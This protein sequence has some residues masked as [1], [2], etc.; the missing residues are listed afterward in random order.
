ME[1]L[2]FI[3]EPMTAS[4]FNGW[5]REDPMRS[6]SP[7]ATHR[8]GRHERTVADLRPADVTRE[9]LTRRVRWGMLT[10][11]LTLAAALVGGGFWLWQRPSAMADAAVSNI[12]TQAGALQPELTSLQ[13]I[14]QQLLEPELDLSA[15]SAQS[16]AV[17]GEARA[18]FDAS[19]AVPSSE[20]ATR[21]LAADVASTAIDASR[22]LSSATAYRSAILPILV[23]PDL[24]TDPELIGLDDAVRD[25]GAW[26]SQF[27][28]VRSA[29]PEGTLP[30]V[31]E[32]LETI[33]AGLESIQ[34]GYL[35]AL[36]EDDRTAADQ[37]V[38]DIE[39]QLR[40]VE[41]VLNVSLED[42]QTR[43][44]RLTDEAL[45]G[46]DQLLS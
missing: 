3:D 35:D 2:G 19:G 43:V 11:V 5:P 10:I 37:Q 45:A 22:I 14:N 44:H 15:V 23:P 28:E 27:D 8:R 38:R 16:A 9:L 33:S 34:A 18:L 1:A 20:A 36:R 29:L 26:Q 39:D 32:R 13:D 25:F 42:V 12:S 40:D 31:T 17:N 4:T 41:A 6:P 21:R 30:D 7:A 24:E 46:I